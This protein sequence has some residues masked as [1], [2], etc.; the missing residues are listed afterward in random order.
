MTNDEICK[1][2]GLDPRRYLVVDWSPV[3]PHQR[4][5]TIDQMIAAAPSWGGNLTP[6]IEERRAIVRNVCGSK[7]DFERHIRELL[8]DNIGDDADTYSEADFVSDLAEDGWPDARAWLKIWV[9]LHEGGELTP[10]ER[11]QALAY[12]TAGENLPAPE[13]RLP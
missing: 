9:R 11:E 1:Q 4:L 13:D 3:Q 10:R 12:W 2:L 5:A 6:L 8:R 7:A